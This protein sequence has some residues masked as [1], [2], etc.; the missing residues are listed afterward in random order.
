MKVTLFGATGRT[1]KYVLDQALEAGHE[2][3]AVVRSPEKLAA[4]RPGLTVIQGD[5]RDLQTVSDAIT[6]AGAVISTLGPARGGPMDV[7]TRGA[8]NIVAAMRTHGVSRL[9]ITTGAGVPA[10]EDQPNFMSKF[11]GFL[12]RTLSREVY[13]DALRGAEIVKNSGLDW[14]IV[15]GP[16]LID[17]PVDGDYRAGY[18]GAGMNRTLSRGNFADFILKQLDDDTFRHKIP[19]VSDN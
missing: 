2:I 10:P 12:V 6:G 4:T 15:R 17:R 5:A 14:T 9:I 1:G 8:E 3:T 13:E 16:M 7:M 11:M 19:A 18:V